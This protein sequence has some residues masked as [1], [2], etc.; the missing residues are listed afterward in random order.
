[1]DVKKKKKTLSWCEKRQDTAGQHWTSKLVTSSHNNAAKQEIMKQHGGKDDCRLAL[2]LQLEYENSSDQ[3]KQ[4]SNQTV[5]GYC[6]H[7]QSD[8]NCSVG[9]HKWSW[10]D[11]TGCKDIISGD[12]RLPPKPHPVDSEGHLLLM[13]LNTRRPFGCYPNSFW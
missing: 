9:K 8:M 1:M 12:G 13:I 10:I 6:A 4:R 11:S 3:W 2:R 7:F 5:L